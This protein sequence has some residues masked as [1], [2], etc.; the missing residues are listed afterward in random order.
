MREEISFVGS[1]GARLRGV[2]QRP[3]APVRG[4][5]L[6]AHCFTCSKDLHTITRLARRLNEAGWATMAFDF[7]G[8]GESGGS[9]AHSTVTTDVGDLRRAALAMI[10]R[11]VGPCLLLGHSLGGAAAILA[12]R[13]IHT[14]D[15]VICVA[16]P[17]DV[18]HVRRLLVPAPTASGHD[19][20][21]AADGQDPNEAF[22]VEIGGRPFEISPA[23]LADLEHHDVA[24]VARTLGVPVLVVEAGADTV[25]GS[26]Q[27]QRLAE[28]AGAELAVVEGA[29][30]LFSD[31]DHAR[32][33]GEIVVEWATRHAPR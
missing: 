5:V 19:T 7:T 20:T 26:D 14:L 31:A 1:G 6:L 10:Q 11:G 23:F 28:A 3:S 13:S 22:T 15:G 32:R 9:F 4:A 8:L 21:A 17:V 27:T 33:L 16:S 12:A 18:T 29:D 2:L 24:V 25:V 30:H